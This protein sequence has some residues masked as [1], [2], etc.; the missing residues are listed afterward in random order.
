[1]QLSDLMP[2]IAGWMSVGWHVRAHTST[3]ARAR[4]PCTH[5]SALFWVHHSEEYFITSVNT[6]CGVLRF[7]GERQVESCK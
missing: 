2:V 4:R 6:H 7:R 3:R 1:M 5:V